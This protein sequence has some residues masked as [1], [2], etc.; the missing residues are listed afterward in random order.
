MSHVTERIANYSPELL[1]QLARRANKKNTSTQQIQPRSR[2]THVFPLSFAQ[3]RLWF[4][5]RLFP[6]NSA[7]NIPFALHF[8]LPAHLAAGGFTP[9]LQ[10][11]VALQR[12]IV[13]DMVKRHEIWRTSFPMRNGVPVQV[14]NPA[15]PVP[16]EVVVLTDVSESERLGA[17]TRIIVDRVN[18]LFDLTGPS[19]C[20]FG[21]IQLSPSEYVAFIIC[22]HIVF[23]AWSMRV[24]VEEFRLLLLSALS[25]KAYRPA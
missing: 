24:A 2:D 15:A 13:D 21:M 16:L 20:R 17:A 22:H 9:G 12:S 4:L 3:E 6:G 1:R 19:Q 11:V 18:Q 23:D 7:Y 10:D 25:G 14:I 8:S 5:D